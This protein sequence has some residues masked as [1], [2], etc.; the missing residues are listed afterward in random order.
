MMQ[1]S[2]LE[3]KV[4]SKDDPLPQELLTKLLASWE[5]VS[6]EESVGEASLKESFELE[7]RT[8][9]AQYSKL[10]KEQ[11]ALNATMAEQEDLKQK[12][13]A[14]V[15]YLETTHNQ[16][17]EQR[18]S[19]RQFARRL[20]NRPL[21]PTLQLPELTAETKPKS[22]LLAMKKPELKKPALTTGKKL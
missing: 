5:A 1:L 4:N 14:A 9:E 3:K 18:T 16:L 7:L 8:G 22:A 21:P 17:L 6:K 19:L 2:V 15:S 12:L 11:T 20:S 13:T 10:L